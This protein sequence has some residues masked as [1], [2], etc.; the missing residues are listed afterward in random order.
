MCLS[1]PSPPSLN[2]TTPRPTHDLRG[3]AAGVEV[4]S[5]YFVPGVLFLNI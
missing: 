3:S 2:P 1:L 5:A 4:S